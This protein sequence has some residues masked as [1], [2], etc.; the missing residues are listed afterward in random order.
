M[1]KERKWVFLQ[2]Y[3]AVD[4]FSFIAKETFL[5][6]FNAAMIFTIQQLVPRV[7]DN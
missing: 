4:R 1:K 3:Y 6:S 2:K 5:V 7:V